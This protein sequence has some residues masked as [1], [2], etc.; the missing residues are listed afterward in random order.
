[1]HG[2]ALDGSALLEKLAEDV[3][4]AD[5][6]VGAR[7]GYRATRR[8][9]A[10]EERRVADPEAPVAPLVLAVC[11]DV[12]E[13][14]QHSKAA[15]VPVDRVERRA[16]DERGRAVVGRPAA[17]VALD[18]GQRAA[19]EVGQGVRPRPLHE[20]CAKRSAVDLDDRRLAAPHL[21]PHHCPA[22]ERQLEASVVGIPRCARPDEG[23]VA[24]AVVETPVGV[25][26][27]KPAILAGTVRD[28]L[29]LVGMVEPEAL[30][31]RHVDA[32]DTCVGHP[33]AILSVSLDEP[34][35]GR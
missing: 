24:L 12:V 4:I 5:P 20:V 8:R 21:S 16:G 25:D 30:D 3:A 28:E 13:L 27:E 35:A 9:V 1:M 23:E 29:D 11:G 18:E 6:G 15:A 2:L 7:R 14:E 19:D 32:C 26:E 34:R 31:R 33:R 17:V 10:G 22:G